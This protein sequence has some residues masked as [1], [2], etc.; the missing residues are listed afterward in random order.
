MGKS[1]RQFLPYGRL[2]QRYTAHLRRQE[3]AKYIG[4]WLAEL[5]VDSFLPPVEYYL[6]PMN[7]AWAVNIVRRAAEECKER[8]IRRSKLYEALDFLEKNI[9]AAVLVRQYRRAL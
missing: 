8:E 4:L 7:T 2:F 6:T 9:D 5:S 1:A 3:T